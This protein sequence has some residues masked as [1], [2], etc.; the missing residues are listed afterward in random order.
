MLQLHTHTTVDRTRDPIATRDTA[1]YFCESI[2]ERF[3]EEGCCSGVV[4]GAAFLTGPRLMRAGVAGA[5]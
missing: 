4:R 1:I 3:S 5:A 2:A